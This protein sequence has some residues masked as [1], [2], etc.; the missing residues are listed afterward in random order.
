MIDRRAALAV[1]AVLGALVLVDA[2]SIG[3]DPQLFRT[4]VSPDGLLAPLVRAADS[5]WE[6]G[7]V[8]APALL[9]GVL[10]AAAAA[11]GLG[12]RAW[13]RWILVVIALAVVA[14]LLVPAVLL[15]VG[16]RES[17]QPW[18]YTNDSTYQIELAGDLVLDGDSP[19][20]HEYRGSGLERW[21]RDVRQ[22]TDQGRAAL[23]HF[24]Y[25]PGTVLTAAAWR[26]LPSPLDD[27]RLLV[28]L[29]TFGLFGAAFLFPAPFEARLA[30]GAL[31]AANPLAARAP[32]F[33]TADAPSVLLAVLAFALLTRR[34][35]GWAAAS[36]AG[37]VLLKQ[38]AFVA[39]PFFGLALVGLGVTIET[40]RRAGLVFVGV[41]A[42]GFLPFLVAGPAAVLDDTI[43]YG[44]STYRI[45]GYG[46]AGLLVEAGMASRNGDYPFALV[47][48]VVWAPLTAWLLLAQARLGELWA[49]AAGAAISLFAL[50]WVSRVFQTSYVLWPFTFLVLA[51]LLFFVE[52]ARERSSSAYTRV[53]PTM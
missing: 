47:A 48:A 46:L 31:L 43:S 6:L 2:P 38:F 33:G 49:A 7:F 11:A 41:L 20:G 30:A 19:Y 52:R 28:L 10:V 15:G 53:E 13:R 40:L 3:T 22:P 17:S 39:V 44:A 32:W 25:F 35:F 42:A 51:G 24:A 5:Q 45:I 14:L 9:A 26:L 4:A 21:Y 12:V 29:A 8:R 34:R 37:A 18:A 27:Y 36:L 23:E 50:F 16:L 1:L